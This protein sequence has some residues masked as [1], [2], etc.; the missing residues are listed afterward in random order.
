M[1]SMGFKIAVA[2]ALL[3]MLLEGCGGSRNL[4]QYEDMPESARPGRL[5]ATDD[6]DR[7]RPAWLHETRPAWSR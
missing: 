4:A 2:A 7:S 3:S 5:N 6:F 1:T